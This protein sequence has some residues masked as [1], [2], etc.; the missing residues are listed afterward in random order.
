MAAD[1]G[2]VMPAMR[3]SAF[4]VC[5]HYPGHSRSS[6]ELYEDIL[7]EIVLAEELGY[8]SYWIAE[9][10][11]HEYGI[12]TNPAMFLAAAA[13]RTTTIRLGPAVALL[14]FR[15]PLTVAED[16][17][18]LDRLS[19]GRLIMGVGSGYLKHEFA[20][21]AI[22]IEDKRERFDV[23]L[24][25]IKRAWAGESIHHDAPWFSAGGARLAVLPKQQPHPPIYV[26]VLRR[27]AA[28]YVGRQGNR[29]MAMPYASVDRMEEVGELIA[30]YRK[31]VAESG[32]APADDQE[33]VGLHTYV[34][35]SDDEARA[36]AADA[37][38]L[39]VE[40]RLYARRQV[41]DDIIRSRLALFGSV[42]TVVDRLVELHG[43]GLN[44]VV[45]LINFG[46]IA[47]ERVRRSMTLIANEV[48]PRV[49][50]RLAAP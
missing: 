22:D 2:G 28:Y 40:T 50:A 39:Y 43:L 5:D 42:D 25:V 29:L 49:N 35:E 10:H 30:E 41:Y 36:H 24:D 4:S 7:R 3:F 33:V 8:Y 12:V 47:P 34:A 37:F 17:A 27:E 6:D 16:Y 18:I 9:H 20:G 32:V 15:N 46:D 26:A 38:D 31:G 23:S 45:M 11:F 21:F 48:M 13:Q 14:T 19:G 1:Q 44:H